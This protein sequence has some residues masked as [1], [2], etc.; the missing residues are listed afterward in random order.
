MNEHTAS[1][2]QYT[3]TLKL[4]IYLKYNEG[5][6]VV[7]V[8]RYILQGQKTLCLVRETNPEPLHSK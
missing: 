2:C 3:A 5:E 8:L 7:A 6:A 1:D 4:T